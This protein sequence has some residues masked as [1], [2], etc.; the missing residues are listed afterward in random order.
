MILLLNFIKCKDI[1][2]KIHGQPS[3]TRRVFAYNLY[4]RC[5]EIFYKRKEVDSQGACLADDNQWMAPKIK[6]FID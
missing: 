5:D 6:E 2:I 4:Y 3:L 1:F